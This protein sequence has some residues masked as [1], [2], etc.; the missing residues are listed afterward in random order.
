MKLVLGLKLRVWGLTL[1]V[2]YV[3][4]WVNQPCFWTPAWAIGDR[5]HDGGSHPRNGM[6]PGCRGGGGGVTGAIRV[7]WLLGGVMGATCVRRLGGG[8]F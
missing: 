1:I 6:A 2:R 7:G 4:G 3:G 8:G 5:L